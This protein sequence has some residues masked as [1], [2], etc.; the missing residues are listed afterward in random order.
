MLLNNNPDNKGGKTEDIDNILE[1]LQKKKIESASSNDAPTRIDTQAVKPPVHSSQQS[2]FSESENKKFGDAKSENTVPKKNERP[3]VKS[4]QAPSFSQ[5]SVQSQ[6]PTLQSHSVK[7]T[8]LPG[9][10]NLSDFDTQAKNKQRYVHKEKNKFYVPGYVKVIVYLAAVFTVSI[11]LAVSAIKIGNDVFAFV[12]P[13]KEITFT[14]KENATLDDV[15]NTLYDNGLINYPSV[16]KLYSKFRMDG[17]DYYTGAFLAG[18]HTFSTTTSYDKFIESLAVSRFKKEVVRVT[19]PEGFTVLEILDLIEEK[20]VINEIS[21]EK[22]VENINCSYYNY[23][24]LEDKP[25]S[26]AEESSFDK[27]QHMATGYALLE[28]FDEKNIISSSKKQQYKTDVKEIADS[29]ATPRQKINSEKFYNLEGYLFPDTYDFYVG[30][31]LDSLIG[32]FLANFNRKF[33]ESYYDRCQELGM[34]IDE[35]IT[36]ASMIEAEGRTAEDFYN[37]SSVFHNRLRNAASFPFLNSDA[38]TLY[39]FQGEKKKLDAGDNQTRVHP[40]NTYLNKGLP[41]GPICNPGDEAIH[42]ALYP[43]STNYKY[44]Y[45]AST[46]GITYFSATEREHNNYVYRDRVGTLG[47]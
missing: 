38:T 20:R 7:T 22:L 2:M 26:K 45:T 8:A 4:P 10:V 34:T 18:E 29:L 46:N 9:A 15:A 19:I 3:N 13:E 14:I 33:D 12:K 44:F 1:I 11:L 30:E 36:L 40:Y 37:I 21:R 17:K 16:Y 42:A 35:V 39:S 43:E 41:P 24:F 32:K 5:R 6:K 28:L 25:S 23:R 31:D 27:Y 47:N